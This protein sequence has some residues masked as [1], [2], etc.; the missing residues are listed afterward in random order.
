MDKLKDLAKN[1]DLTQVESI[2]LK[3]LENKL[4]LVTQRQKQIEQ[5]SKAFHPEDTVSH[6]SDVSEHHYLNGHNYEV[7]RAVE[8]RSNDIKGLTND[9]IQKVLETEK[10][11]IKTDKEFKQLPP[12]SHD[13]ICYKG[14]R[15]YPVKNSGN[16]IPF[17]LMQNAKVGDVIVLD[18]GYTYTA[19]NR[20]LAENYGGEI[21]RGD[22]GSRPQKLMM[23]DIHFPKGAKVSRNLEHGGE[24]VAPSGA[25]Y[26]VLS[27]KIYDNGDIDGVVRYI[28]PNA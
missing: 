21:A 14:F 11:M 25:R 1:R 26:E 28:L 10:W 5:E 12:L 7:R 13:C 22:F 16:N 8:A 27:K 3:Y 19:F 23:L 18:T 2:R 4:S 9:E 6:F 15:E 20:G 17:K 24:A